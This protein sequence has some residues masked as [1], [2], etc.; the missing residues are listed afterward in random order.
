MFKQTGRYLRKCREAAGISQTELQHKLGYRGRNALVSRVEGGRALYPKAKFSLLRTL[1]KIEDGEL[2]RAMCQDYSEAAY[3]E[4]APLLKKAGK[5]FNK[6]KV[7][8]KA[9]RK[10]Q[11]HPET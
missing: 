5:N 9:L 1:V 8:K 10:G 2:I 4:L 7:K 6:V 11:A 3:T